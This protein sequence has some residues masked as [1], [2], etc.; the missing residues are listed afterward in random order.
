MGF[1]QSKSQEI[2][3]PLIKR[4]EK[5]KIL[6]LGDEATGKTTL[7]YK[8][9]LSEVEDRQMSYSS[10]YIQSMRSGNLT[11]ECFDFSKKFRNMA[12]FWSQEYQNTSAIIYVINLCSHIEKEYIDWTINDINSKNDLKKCPILIFG[13]MLDLVS[14][15]DERM[16]MAEAGREY[17]KEIGKKIENQREWTFMEGSGQNMQGVYEALEWLVKK[18]Q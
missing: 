3:A 11:V 18:I 15:S 6:I 8:L 1:S 16:I 14:T 10:F 5:S 12:D 2:L 9:N 7:L 13:N 4:K 17:V